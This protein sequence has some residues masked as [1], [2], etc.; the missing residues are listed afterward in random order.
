[1][2]HFED[3]LRSGFQESETEK[4]T[5]PRFI[6]DGEFFKSSG[7]SLFD[8][9]WKQRFYRL[10]K[11]ARA[12]R[13]YAD[14]GRSK[15]LGAYRIDAAS[16]ITPQPD[17]A[18]HTNVLQLVGRH[19]GGMKNVLQF[20]VSTVEAKDKLISAINEVINEAKAEL[21]RLESS[22][23]DTAGGSD[24]NSLGDQ[25]SPIA[26]ICLREGNHFCADCSAPH[27]R[28]ISINNL[29]LICTECS[30]IHRSLGVEHSFVQSVTLDA[31]APEV[32]DALLH[33]HTTAEI[34]DEKLEYSVP[35]EIIK[36]C[37]DS[38]REFKETYIRLKYVDKA[39]VYKEDKTHLRP[40]SA[41]RSATAAAEKMNA[42]SVGAIDMVGILQVNIKYA[43]NLARGGGLASSLK[44]AVRCDLNLGR[45]KL[46]STIKEGTDNPQWGETIF[47]TW[48]G[49]SDLHIDMFDGDADI[50]G[51][52][53]E[54]LKLRLVD[55]V[56]QEMN[57]VPLEDT[58]SGTITFEVML[59][60]LGH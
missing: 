13:Y 29:V 27:P 19:K 21:E 57:D 28:W 49:K 8:M 9:F 46:R 30:G 31:I 56:T 22:G 34:N 18:M 45:Q 36:P 60:K 42:L 58:S 55:G 47:L 54:L 48:D 25:D 44:R 40:V 26:H 4:E 43:K 41:V 20:S 39:F 12:L 38:T 5:D 50:G 35:E 14:E 3:Y 2:S 53:V 11:K 7:H 37:P 59:Q 16:S 1:M 52:T 23:G 33:G 32:L 15:V 17:T 6:V 51:V 24:N 10:D